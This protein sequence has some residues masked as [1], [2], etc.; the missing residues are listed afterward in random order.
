MITLEQIKIYKKY[1]ADGDGFTRCATDD[2]KSIIDYKH[3]SLIADLVQDLILI[4]KHPV[5]ESFKRSVDAKLKDNC[6]NEEV[7][8]EL[9]K[10][11]LL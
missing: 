6:I 4:R 3:W 9:I 7:L 5:S 2:E 10:I 11:S 1:S 8:K